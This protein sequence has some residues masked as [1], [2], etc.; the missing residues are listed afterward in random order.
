M[1]KYTKSVIFWTLAAIV[2]AV[3]V[4][5]VIQGAEPSPY[6]G[7]DV[8]IDEITES[9]WSRGNP[10]A[11][12]TFIEYSDFQCPACDL[13]AALTDEMMKEYGNHVNFAYRHFPLKSIHPNAM[14]AARAVNAAGQQGQFFEMHN[15]LFLNK[16][17][18]EH[19]NA[20]DVELAF[21]EFA[22]ELKLDS[23]KFYEDYNSKDNIQS[24]ENDYN[25]AI[26]VGLTYTPSFFLNGELTRMPQ[27]PEAF[28]KIIR[29]A[30]EAVE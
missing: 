27:N 11:K 18:W 16:Y 29:D 21:L 19:E 7:G 14:P 30:I 23:K 3:S 24:V 2:I 10:D 6:S 5:I 22:D 9:D 20:E 26:K 8:S 4:F 28:N 1:N 15:L 25:N 12:V 13:F 17:H